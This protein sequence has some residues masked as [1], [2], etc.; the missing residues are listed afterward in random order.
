MKM[1]NV[2]WGYGD[3]VTMAETKEEAIQKFLKYAP[4][5]AQLETRKSYDGIQSRIPIDAVSEVE[6]EVTYFGE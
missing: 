5:L 1:W 3:L 6:T 4:S 2:G